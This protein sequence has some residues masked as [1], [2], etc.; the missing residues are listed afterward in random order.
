[1]PGSRLPHY[2]L[3]RGGIRVSTLDLAGRWMLLAGPQGTPWLPAAKAAAQSFAQL[4]LDGWRVGGE[5]S[6]PSGEFA[7]SVGISANQPV[8][9]GRS[10]SNTTIFRI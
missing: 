9:A 10:P 4:P 1:M 3:E 6:D 5:L 8:I 2:W 7:P